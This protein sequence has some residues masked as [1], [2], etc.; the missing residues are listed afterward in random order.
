M[1]QNY[2][3]MNIPLRTTLESTLQILDCYI[4][5]VICL[6]VFF[7]SS[8]I[9]SLIHWL[10]NRILSNHHTF[11]VF[12]FF[13]LQLF[14]SFRPLWLENML[15][16]I[17]VFLYLLRFDSFKHLTCVLPPENVPS[18]LENILSTILDGIFC[19]YLLSLSVSCVKANVSL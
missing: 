1:R 16:M 4:P 8:F 12:P 14:S 6:K 3:T 2:F 5:I 17:S 19:I 11:M 18:A 10:R 9:S 15:D 7:I 13:F